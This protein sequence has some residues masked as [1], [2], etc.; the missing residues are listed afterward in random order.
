LLL[1]PGYGDADPLPATDVAP[2]TDALRD[3]LA[4]ALAEAFIERLVFGAALSLGLGPP[5]ESEPE[6]LRA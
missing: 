2:A 4:S 6:A 5:I 1:I 3:R